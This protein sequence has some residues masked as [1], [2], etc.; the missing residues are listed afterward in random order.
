MLRCII[1]I[2]ESIKMLNFNVQCPRTLEHDLN[3]KLSARCLLLNNK[4]RKITA[5]S[6]NVDGRTIQLVNDIVY[7][8][9]DSLRPRNERMIRWVKIY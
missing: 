2:A 4:S 8:Y 3:S 7:F 9:S 1:E 6:V 5:I